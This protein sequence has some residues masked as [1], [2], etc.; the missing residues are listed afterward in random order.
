MC[1]CKCPKY[2]KGWCSLKIADICP[3]NKN[4]CIIPKKIIIQLEILDYLKF[5]K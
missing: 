2:E 1:Y 4:N 3:Y 5:K